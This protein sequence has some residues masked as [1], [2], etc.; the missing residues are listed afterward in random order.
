MNQGMNR[1]N[2][3][4]YRGGFSDEEV[5]AGGFGESNFGVYDADRRGGGTSGGKRAGPKGYQRSDERVREDVC[6]RLIECRYPVHDVEVNVVAG[7]VTLTG[8]VR[9]RGLKYRIEEIVDDTFG[10]KEV[11]NRLRIGADA[12]ATPSQ[13]AARPGST[14]GGGISGLSTSSA[15][16]EGSSRGSG[17]V[18]PDKAGTLASG[19]DTVGA[20]KAGSA[21]V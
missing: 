5:Y 11:D 12:G 17:A 8:S 20:T 3:P 19:T 2:E 9:D 6:E 21:T 16:T 4:D 10:V 14:G 15:T 7:V 1:R 18:S 13:G